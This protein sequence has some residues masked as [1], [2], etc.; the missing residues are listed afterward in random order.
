[1]AV[2][3]ILVRHGETKWNDIGKFQGSEDIE[4]NNTGIQQAESL[5]ERLNDLKLDKIYSSNLKRAY[6]TAN[7]VANEHQLEVKEIAGLQEIDFGVWEG[8][9][10]DEI[11]ERFDFTLEDWLRA[12]VDTRVPEGESLL[13]VKERVV[14][15]CKDILAQHEDEKILIVAHGGVNKVL[16]SDLLEMPLERSWNLEQDNTAVNKV[17]FYQSHLSLRLLNCTA[18]LR[19]SC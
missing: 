19:D 4:L 6:K 12:S 17:S 18:H 1:M 3:L 14:P 15:A 10:F 8:L 11:K 7:I 9:G 13:D 16:L 2:E 5:A